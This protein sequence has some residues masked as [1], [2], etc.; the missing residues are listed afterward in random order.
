MS[1]FAR[2]TTP[3]ITLPVRVH[4]RALKRREKQRGK[5]LEAM[6]EKYYRGDR[7][8]PPIVSCRRTELNHFKGQ[9]YPPFK[10]LPLA[11]EHWPSR[12][13]VGDFFSF[14]PFR[15]AAATNW[16]YQGGKDN[17]PL[18]YADDDENTKRDSVPPTFSDYSLDKRLVLALKKCG[19]KKPTN[20]QHAALQQLMGGES[21]LI[22]AETGNGKTLAF[23]LPVIQRILAAKEILSEQGESNTKRKYNSPFA[24]IA[25]PG[26]E[27]AWQIKSVAEA[28][29]EELNVKVRFV[30]GSNVDS[31]IEHGW[32]GEVDIL[33][34][35]VGGLTKMF[36]GRLFFAD[37]VNSIVLDEID[38]MVDD[39]FKGVTSNLL[40]QL[41]KNPGGQQ[42]ILAGAT[43]PTSLD[44]ALSHVMDTESLGMIKTHY[45]HR[46][47]P[48]MRQKFI[49]APKTNRQEYLIDLIE[50]DVAKK[51]KVLIFCNKSSTSSYVSHWLQEQGINCL[52]FSGANMNPHTRRYNLEEFL[53]GQECHALSCTDLVSRGLDVS[54]H[55]VVNYDFPFTVADY[56]HRVGR[57][58]RVG[59][60]YQGKVT[61]LVCGQVSIGIVQ[62]LEKAVRLN[63]AIA[64]VETNIIG[65]IAE[66]RFERDGIEGNI[67]LEP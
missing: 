59:N 65:A 46:V 10:K 2:K 62:E 28:L 19:L 53:H 36:E 9:V 39:T 66:R 32:R 44:S 49:R 67:D 4:Q 52:H 18:Q 8:V 7:D 24:V 42:M 29:C 45:L 3:I 35:S 17:D 15:G 21:S 23:L 30:Q 33:V 56:I 51:R 37:F 1:G 20:V 5:E 38:T 41:Q 13:T 50:E 6:H 61:S 54:V 63:R 11:S 12:R 48:H 40:A 58:G 43:V 27:L 34:G 64:N 47:M 55:H 14:N 60:K 16:F 22:A 31:K 57:V 25:T 26:R